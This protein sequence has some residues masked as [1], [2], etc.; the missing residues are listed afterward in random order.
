MLREV[1]REEI[2][3]LE[4]LESFTREQYQALT[5]KIENVR[6]L[7]QEFQKTFLSGT[8][9]MAVLKGIDKLAKEGLEI[10]KTVLGDNI[11]SFVKIPRLAGT[12][13]QQTIPTVI[14]KLE[15]LQTKV[16]NKLGINREQIA[17]LRRDLDLLVR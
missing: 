7:E 4:I 2:A 1:L 17:N 15:E 3:E 10:A 11:Y 9:T 13:S 6:F 12:G 8:G 5:T 14:R 16:E